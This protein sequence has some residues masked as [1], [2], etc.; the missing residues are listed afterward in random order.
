MGAG[1]ADIAG[2]A[3]DRRSISER[4]IQASTGLEYERGDQDTQSQ[5]HQMLKSTK[6]S[7]Y[8]PMIIS[9]K[10]NHR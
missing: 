6:D 9:M 3:C 7:R 10:Q 1:K 2:A 8:D 5:I 4:S